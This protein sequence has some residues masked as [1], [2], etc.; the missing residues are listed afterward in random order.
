MLA[1][2]NLNQ[3]HRHRR[4]GDLVATM[5]W[6]TTRH[7]ETW[8]GITGLGAVCHT[9]NP[10]L[11]DKDINFIINDAA[12]RLGVFPA[13]FASVGPDSF[14]RLPSPPLLSILHQ[15]CYLISDITFFQQLERVLPGC[16][17]IKGVIFLTDR[18][19]HCTSTASLGE[20]SLPAR[21]IQPAGAAHPAINSH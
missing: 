4:E 10:R 14:P 8:Y 20:N 18:Q 11:S 7:M 9:V 13:C 15:D 16:P 2:H 1:P 3:K 6:N 21:R 17:S 19:V 5:A 12:V